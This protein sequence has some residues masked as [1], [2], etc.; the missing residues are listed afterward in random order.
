[1]SN[2]KRVFI[3]ILIMAFSAL[4]VAGITIFSLY[5]AAMSEQRERLVE[6]SKSQARLIEAAAKFNATS[7]MSDRLENARAATLSQII[8]AHNNYEQSGRTM[9]FTLAERR[10]DSINFLLRHRYGELKQPKSFDFY[11]KLAEPM[12]RAL[13]GHS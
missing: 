9:E 11:L 10:G 8:E 5:Q 1:M 3:L 12:R 13:S 7:G 6:T 2:R 4:I